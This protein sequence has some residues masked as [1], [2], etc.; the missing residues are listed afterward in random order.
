MRRKS[1]R[2]GTVSYDL[3]FA[4]HRMILP[5]Y[6]MTAS[7]ITPE[8]VAVM[9]VEGFNPARIAQ[10]LKV[11]TAKVVE[12]VH[13]C[14]GQGR[15]RRSEVLFSLSKDFRTQV[16]LFEG[17]ELSA[18]RIQTFLSHGLY[19]ESDLEEVRLY[20]LYRTSRAQ[21]GEM[22]DDLCVLE[23]TLHAKI[24]SILLRKF[25]EKDNQWWGTGIPRAVRIACAQAR[26]DN[27]EFQFHAY[28]YTTLIHLKTILDDNW[29]LFSKRL[30]KTVAQNKKQFAIDLNRLNK[31][32]NQVMHPVRGEPT[33]EDLHFVRIMRRSLDVMRWRD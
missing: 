1:L 6:S 16:D 33:S 5:P 23:R 13:I 12:T 25:G 14:V 22:Y 15:L 7:R 18:E 3:P 32:R 26:E 9:I 2:A 30:P 20:I 21:I 28:D 31:V 29:S 19:P 4:P 24:K 17:R 10:E 27:P 11:S 8:R